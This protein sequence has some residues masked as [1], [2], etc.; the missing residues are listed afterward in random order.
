M[1]ITL[2][3]SVA[4]GTNNFTT[5]V[6][7][8]AVT[9]AANVAVGDFL[10]AYV[11]TSNPNSA[12]GVPAPPAGWTSILTGP[13]T[14]GLR[15]TAAWKIA[16][17]D[18]VSA[19]SHTWTIGSPTSYWSAACLRF[20]GV[21]ATTP[22]DVTTVSA[23]GSTGTTATA[24]TM[25]GQTTVTADAYIVG[26]L[27]MDDAPTNATNPVP[28]PFTLTQGPMTS[29][30]SIK[31]G[32]YIKAAAGATGTSTWTWTAS[33]AGAS[34]IG[35]QVALRPAPPAVITEDASSPANISLTGNTGACTT[36]AFNP[37][38]GSLLVAI[39]IG[40]YGSSSAVANAATI[41]TVTDNAG[42]TWTRRA[43]AA[44]PAGS[45]ENG[46][47]TDI[48]TRPVPAA[49]TNVT[50]SA[51]FA[52]LTGG[53]HLAV[54]VLTGA[55]T[56]TFGTAL[57]EAR[58]TVSDSTTAGVTHTATMNKS[59]A[60]S[61]I[62]GG[63]SNGYRASVLTPTAV[64]SIITPQHSNPASGGDDAAAAAWRTTNT[65]AT[66]NITVGGTWSVGG[67]GNLAA[68]E[69]LPATSSSGTPPYAD[70]LYDP[71]SG[72]APLTVTFTNIS[73]GATSYLWDFGDGV[74]S[75][76]TSPVYTFTTA[77]TYS[78]KLTATNASG[79]DDIVGT[80]TVSGPVA[81]AP[82][83]AATGTALAYSSTARTTS[84]IPAP[85][86]V[87]AN[88]VVL[89]FLY[90][91]ASAQTTMT[92]P[93]GAGFTPITFN[94]VPR[95]T[96]S[97]AVTYTNWFWKRAT[98]ADSGNYTF[99]HNSMPTEGIAFRIT[100]CA[101][102][103]TP[104]E[105]LNSAVREGS[106][107]T[108]VAVS[109]TTSGANRLL[110]WSVASWSQINPTF[111]T[112]PAPAWARVFDGNDSGIAWK[113]QATT[114]GT[115]TLTATHESGNSAAAL[116]GLI[117]KSISPSATEHGSTPAVKRAGPGWTTGTI[118]ADPF[119]PAA[120]SIL[121]ATVNL[122]YAASWEGN[123]PEVT[124]TDNTGL[125]WFSLGYT[126]DTTTQQIAAGAWYAIARVSTPTTVTATRAGSLGVASGQ[127]AVR[128]M[129]SAEIPLLRHNAVLTG[130]S[131][132]ASTETQGVGSLVHAA[133]VVD[134]SATL[135]PTANLTD[136]DNWSNTTDGVSLAFGRVTAPPDSTTATTYG[137]TAP[138][139]PF[140]VTFV[141]GH[142][143][144][145][146]AGAING[147]QAVIP[148]ATVVDDLMLVSVVIDQRAAAT[149]GLTPAQSFL[150]P[151][152]WT[153]LGAGSPTA[154]NGALGNVM[155][156]AKVATGSDAS[157]NVLF[158]HAAGVAAYDV[159]GALM[160]FRGAQIP[161]ALTDL[162]PAYAQD[163]SAGTTIGAPGATINA[164]GA[165]ATFWHKGSNA[166]NT[167]YFRGYTNSLVE[168]ADSAA[169][170]HR[171]ASAAAYRLLAATTTIP[172]STATMY[173]T[174][175]GSTTVSSTGT[176]V[177]LALNAAP[178]ATLREVVTIVETPFGVTPIGPSSALTATAEALVSVEP[179]IE[180]STDLTSTAS[181]SATIGAGVAVEV[182]STV[183]VTSGASVAIG[184]VTVRRNAT[185]TVTAAASSTFVPGTGSALAV[186]GAATSSIVPGPLTRPS[187]LTATAAASSTASGTK[188]VEVVLAPTAVVSVSSGAVTVRRNATL[189]ATA[190][191]SVAALPLGTAATRATASAG[192]TIAGTTVIRLS[193][194][195]ATAAAGGTIIGQF[196]A[197]RPLTSTA[198]AGV[199]VT[200]VVTPNIAITGAARMT[201]PVSIAVRPPL[202]VTGSAALSVGTTTILHTTAL[203]ARAA[204]SPNISTQLAI[205][206]ALRA[207]ARALATYTGSRIVNL[208][209]KVT[210]D[211]NVAG[212]IA[213]LPERFSTVQV[214]ADMS[215]EPRSITGMSAN[216]VVG[217]FG[218]SSVVTLGP[219]ARF[220]VD[221]SVSGRI[222]FITELQETAEVG[223]RAVARL[224]T[225]QSLTTILENGLPALVTAPQ[226]PPSKLTTPEPEL[227][228]E[229]EPVAAPVYG[230]VFMNVRR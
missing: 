19:T 70:Y 28:T 144:D 179:A 72:T 110:F 17:A 79:S 122:G 133:A 71:V 190:S 39:A 68:L 131:I 128:V 23:A 183:T 125:T 36:A 194:L 92:S 127:L 94:P 18:D 52:Q 197:F 65:A 171:T 14:N 153:P 2:A 87:A 181:A 216:A 119:T 30:I 75:V 164:G 223:I 222:S 1:P 172:A 85:A 35:F 103:G 73:T 152:G 29:G 120:P 7:S 115:G 12:G 137:W 159:S 156:Y 91:E 227:Q 41:S 199:S 10:L 33:Y 8:V 193:A 46:G 58:F 185:L 206:P 174:D 112:T 224:R 229:P 166:D 202:T 121:L 209:V 136:L 77:G 105:V 101:T 145:D 180:T 82:V 109:G 93:A 76:E 44:Q 99:T 98:G 207:T 4:S 226:P 5:L 83:L 200:G 149:A 9:K 186:T 67:D 177:T 51:T 210:V 123:P 165:M 38:A 147:Y 212:T 204:A 154:N 201:V 176:G 182:P 11:S 80:V 60:G 24:F 16:T 211:L 219:P 135:T 63:N 55:N 221:V 106:G 163:I 175:T 138:A 196:V 62:F 157:T 124:I 129:T 220:L 25:P 132:S 134:P 155:T 146:D 158:Q 195:T 230:R 34:L 160:V 48:W 45:T 31:T 150:T 117:P 37:P 107:T 168:A 178:A 116:F 15:T 43:R 97:G 191:G 54:R 104:I 84:N 215:G 167:V 217:L 114:G 188:R 198:S 86:G 78:V 118:V 161:A 74:T 59:T 162:V 90:T 22:V 225:V 148:A 50:V 69:I 88:D 100:G 57:N 189:A 214:R 130:T 13:T 228:P 173:T 151:S 205:G 53:R 108:S 218:D 170:T 32:G 141:G 3:S 213:P 20:T 27:S 81:A 89:V 26:V 66:G 143:N 208:K 95:T 140:G 40:E 184:A 142:A 42:G 187:A 56:A 139:P 126:V 64:E 61:V 169:A 21:H 47:C 96:T 102:T 6:N 113:T 192:A 203:L 49:L 111:P